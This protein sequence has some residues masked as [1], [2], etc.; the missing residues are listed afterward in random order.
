MLRAPAAGRLL[1][2]QQTTA[3]TG[4]TYFTVVTLLMATISCTSA[5]NSSSSGSGAGLRAITATQWNDLASRTLYF[6]H[7]SV[8]FNILDGVRS[9]QAE[10]P[11]IRLQI[12]DGP[13]PPSGP[14]LVQFT[15]G[16]NDD[17]AS[18][19]AEFVRAVA[20]DKSAAPVF[21]WK[22]CYVDVKRETDIAAM[23]ERYRS[24]VDEL[25]RTHPNATIVHVT[26]PLTLA[27][28]SWDYYA[29]KLMGR[30]THR[31]L[32]RKRNLYNNLL[33]KE[34][35]GKDPIFDL[36]AA[37]ST[38]ADGSREFF[39][40]GGKPVY[41]LAPEW[42]ADQGH[43]NAAGSRH[44]AEQFLLTLATLASNPAVKR[45]QVAAK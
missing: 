7:Q 10:N 30:Y 11:Q 2:G 23:F 18:K 3:M 25:R 8:G 43:L 5:P 15:I 13:Q 45:Q 33:K 22:Y 40:Y 14:G 37:E 34:Y 41:Q 6:G 19:T 9:L 44:V 20:G 12:V 29:R 42:A 36:A 31:D 1:T 27:E 17:P 24:G 26:M 32:N 16:Q 28:A 4:I 39:R 38:H 35:E 21:M